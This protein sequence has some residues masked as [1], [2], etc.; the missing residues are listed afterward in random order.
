MK[1]LID[2][3][4]FLQAALEQDNKEVCTEFLNKV[5]S[6]DIE[7]KVTLFHMDASAIILENQGV[8]PTDIGNFYFQAYNSE[9]LEIVNLGI[10]TRLN[11]LANNTHNGLDD[12][13]ILEAFKELEIS[14]IVTYDTDFDQKN[15]ITPEEIL[16]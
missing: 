16:N 4:I 1:Y 14:K 6:G 5:S 11:A 8:S 12:S 3:N 2:A 7:A 13:L 9:G 15:R 10:S